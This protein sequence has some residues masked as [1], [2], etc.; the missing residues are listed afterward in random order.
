MLFSAYSEPIELY[1]MNLPL[2]FVIIDL[3]DY[4]IGL[5]ELILP[6][7]LQHVMNY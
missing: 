1:I 4:L 7:K 3:S 2:T 6:Q 5:I